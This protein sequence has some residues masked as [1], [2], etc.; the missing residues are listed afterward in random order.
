MSLKKKVLLASAA[1]VLAGCAVAGV[2]TLMGG[3]DAVAL[4]EFLQ[5]VL[6]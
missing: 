3:A 4:P 5:K 2:A 1:L 6:G